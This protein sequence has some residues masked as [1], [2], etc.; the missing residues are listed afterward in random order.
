[1]LLGAG[2]VGEAATGG[3]TGAG[4]ADSSSERNKLNAATT[5]AEPIAALPPTKAAS[6][7]PLQPTGGRAF[8]ATA[9]GAAGTGAGP[10]CPP[11]DKSTPTSAKASNVE[12]TGA[13]VGMIGAA[14]ATTA[15]AAAS[16]VWLVAAGAATCTM[17]PHRGHA[18]I[19][20]I[21]DSLR[22]VSRAWHVT[23]VILKGSTREA[24]NGQL[25]LRAR[26]GS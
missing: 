25:A 16:V 21:A 20:P 22:T 19:C 26:R 4:D 5:S 2:S 14:V 15:L 23:Q 7:A 6:F 18:R 12:T 10:K 13:S 1:V 24:F 9:G 3:A 11:I 17:L 8:D